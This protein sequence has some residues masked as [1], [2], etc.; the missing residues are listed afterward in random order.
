M[1]FKMKKLATH[2]TSD[3]RERFAEEFYSLWSSQIDAPE[4]TDSPAPWG[5][6]WEFGSPEELEGSNVEDMA[7]SWFD[8]VKQDIVNALKEEE[9]A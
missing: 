2:L 1:G 7:R 3:E 8:S 9:N 4:D 6:P 5:C